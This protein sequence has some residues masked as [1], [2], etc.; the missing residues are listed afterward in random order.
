MNIL[1][2]T[3]KKTPCHL[4]QQ[5]RLSRKRRAVGTTEVQVKPYHADWLTGGEFRKSRG[6]KVTA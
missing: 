6:P 3:V 5:H 1:W 2:K 4:Y